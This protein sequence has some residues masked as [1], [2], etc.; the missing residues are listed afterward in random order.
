MMTATTQFTRVAGYQISGLGNDDLAFIG[1]LIRND[2]E[3]L[4]NI[5]DPSSGFDLTD[6]SGSIS[7]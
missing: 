2:V 5:S 4:G 3:N 6:K 7:F 1:E